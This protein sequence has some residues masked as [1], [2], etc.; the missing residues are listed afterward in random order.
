MATTLCTLSRDHNGES[1]ERADARRGSSSLITT[2]YSPII[3]IAACLLLLLCGVGAVL[4]IL[5][6]IVGFLA[7]NKRKTVN[8]AGKNMAIWGFVVNGAAFV[9]G[10]IVGIVILGGMA[11]LGSSS[12]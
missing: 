11:S 3:G 6:G 9:I 7:L 12:C 1:T 10:A 8:G 5:G 2:L 4:A